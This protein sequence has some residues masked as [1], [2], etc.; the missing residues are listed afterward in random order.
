[1]IT[2]KFFFDLI[3]PFP[4]SVQALAVVLVIVFFG[5]LK[6]RLFPYVFRRF[7]NW[8][9][10]GRHIIDQIE[11]VVKMTE[12]KERRVHAI[13]ELEA[14]GQI[15]EAVKTKMTHL[16]V[17]VLVEVRRVEVNGRQG[18]E[19]D[20]FIRDFKTLD[21][22]LSVALFKVQAHIL[23]TAERFPDRFEDAEFRQFATELVSSLYSEFLDEVQARFPPRGM[24]IDI[25]VV[26]DHITGQRE[27]IRD[28]MFSALFQV[29]DIQDKARR[30]AKET[31][32]NFQAQK[33][34]L[35]TKK[36]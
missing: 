13:L 16:K 22:V 14:W 24:V 18:Q 33:N 28:T 34:N 3:K 27:A 11:L 6:Q 36:E 32:E 2:E 1:M 35:L 5:I 4:V 9:T 8:D 25:S 23:T 15:R 10:L 12:E 17:L 26:L 7:L 30:N 19:K 21:A 20:F 31:E 29:R